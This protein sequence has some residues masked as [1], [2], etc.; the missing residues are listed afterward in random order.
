MV[1]TGPAWM[2]TYALKRT[3]IRL[4]SVQAS[5]RIPMDAMA[6]AIV[7]ECFFLGD[8]RSGRFVLDSPPPRLRPCR[9]VRALRRRAHDDLPGE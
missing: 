5:I 9:T 3:V 2:E 4:F 7:L 6:K 1:Q 8:E